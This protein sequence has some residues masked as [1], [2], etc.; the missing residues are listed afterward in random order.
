MPN[1]E[2]VGNGLI[3]ILSLLYIKHLCQ[4]ISDI[5]LL[6]SKCKTWARVIL[7]VSCR[8]V[9][10]LVLVMCLKLLVRTLFNV[11]TFHCTDSFEYED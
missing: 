6:E 10:A 5:L 8:M 3:G 2:G 9:D 4:W 1:F 7:D 11:M